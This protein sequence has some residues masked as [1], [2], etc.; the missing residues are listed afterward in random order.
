MMVSLY[1]QDQNAASGLYCQAKFFNCLS[2]PKGEDK[3]ESESILTKRCG[4]S[5]KITSFK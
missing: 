2:I 4:V 1:Y 5:R 3:F